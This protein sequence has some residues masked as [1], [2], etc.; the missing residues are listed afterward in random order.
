LHGLSPEFDPSWRVVSEYALGHHGW[1]LSAMFIAWAISSWSLAFA[2]W[3]QLRTIGGRIGLVLL[4]AAGAGETM[5]AVFDLRQL[6][7]HNLAGAIG[8]TSLP[9]A[10]TLISL[11]LG[12]TQVWRPARRA[13]HRAAYL[14]WFSLA[15]MVLAMISLS[16]NVSVF[17]VP[18]GWPNRL[19]IVVYCGWVMV[20]AWNAIR[21][22]VL[23]Q[24]DR[25]IK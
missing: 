22:K 15:L 21:L 13:M 10:A 20:V 24:N 14:T 25:T 23:G 4:V 12:G 9:M 16:R 8:I 3:H 11:S 1:V 17:K 5:G 18:I 6:V 2:I 7:L 19:L